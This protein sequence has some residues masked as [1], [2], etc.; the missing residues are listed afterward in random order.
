MT[1]VPLEFILTLLGALGVGGFFFFKMNQAKNAGRNEV[2]T[3][4]REAIAEN[5]LKSIRNKERV[6]SDAQKQKD[7]IP[8]NWDDIERLRSETGKS[9][10]S[11]IA[12]ALLQ[13]KVSENNGPS[14]KNDTTRKN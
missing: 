4:E 10:L 6:E 14:E 5:L 7:V 8:N 9:T 13:T 11:E 12:D 1:S 3:K 2:I